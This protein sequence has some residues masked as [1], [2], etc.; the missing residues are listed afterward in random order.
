MTN[1]QSTAWYQKTEIDVAKD[2]KVDPEQGL[3]TAE[4][5]RRLAQY[6]PNKMAEPPKEPGRQAFLRQYQDFIQIILVGAAAVS[7]IIIGDVPTAILL[8][9]LSVINL[10]VPALHKDTIGELPNC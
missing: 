9:G 10:F 1:T 6:G 5:R 8:A 7:L 4:A 3:S 2:L